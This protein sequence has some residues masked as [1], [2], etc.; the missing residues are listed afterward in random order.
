MHMY[1]ENLKKICSNFNPSNSI[2]PGGLDQ[3][4]KIWD[5]AKVMKEID[6]EMDASIPSSLSL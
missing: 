4:V 2:L 1:V 3:S 5:I 6:R